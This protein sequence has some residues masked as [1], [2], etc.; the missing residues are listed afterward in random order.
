MTA[1]SSCHCITYMCPTDDDDDD[2]DG[3]HKGKCN[4]KQHYFIEE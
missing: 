4:K 1:P 3:D 2:D